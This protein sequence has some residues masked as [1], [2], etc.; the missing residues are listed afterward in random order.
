MSKLI[1]E[2]K[3]RGVSSH[4]IN[5]KREGAWLDTTSGDASQPTTGGQ[6]YNICRLTPES[7][8]DPGAGPHLTRSNLSKS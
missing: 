8:G 7:V 2:K 1:V 3:I 5:G 4:F 6:A